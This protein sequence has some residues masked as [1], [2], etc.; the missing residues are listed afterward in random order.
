MKLPCPPWT[1]SSELQSAV[2]QPRNSFRAAEAVEGLNGYGVSGIEAIDALRVGGAM[3]SA[4]RL[5]ADSQ[6]A[7]EQ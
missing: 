3:T 4:S 7:F 6:T 2:S 1:R 5:R